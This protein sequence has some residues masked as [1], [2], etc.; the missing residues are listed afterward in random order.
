MLHKTCLSSL[1]QKRSL[2]T[3]VK[4]I[5]DSGDHAG[6][7]RVSFSNPP[8]RGP[9]MHAKERTQYPNSYVVEYARQEIHEDQSLRET[10][11]VLRDFPFL[12]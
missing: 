11:L 12:M 2:I 10:M 1:R 6:Y 5:S 7:C 4:A 3:T 9:G 8:E